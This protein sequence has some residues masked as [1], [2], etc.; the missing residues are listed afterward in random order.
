MVMFFFF[1][2]RRRHTRCSRDWSSDVCSS[3]LQ[4][5]C[6]LALISLSSRD[7]PER[8]CLSVATEIPFWG[9]PLAGG[10][11]ME[12]MRKENAV[13]LVP[14]L[15]GKARRTL[16]RSRDIALSRTLHRPSHSRGIPDELSRHP[17]SFVANFEML[18]SRRPMG[19][20]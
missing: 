7:N 8:R 2:S 9:M 17:G 20:E 11:V 19:C 6:G 15:G 16:L 1:S 13:A 18:H 3:D 5:A 12:L 14:D 10:L 4:S